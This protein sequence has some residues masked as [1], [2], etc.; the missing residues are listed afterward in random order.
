MNHP[1]QALSL[2]N[3]CMTSQPAKQKYMSMKYG[4]PV[5]NDFFFFV[6]LTWATFDP[7][8]AIFFQD[9]WLTS[10]N[11]CYKESGHSYWL[12]RRSL[13]PALA[14]Q[15]HNILFISL[16][17]SVKTGHHIF[18]HSASRKLG[19]YWQSYKVVTRLCLL[20]QRNELSVYGLHKDN[21]EK[22]KFPFYVRTST[23]KNIFANETKKGLYA[24]WLEHKWQG[25]T[26]FLS[27]HNSFYLHT[28]F[29]KRKKIT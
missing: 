19:M 28:L 9:H 25:V 12:P 16:H 22:L 5:I 17:I 10:M 26:P 24:N 3:T 21:H 4:G 27:Q 23:Q 8:T 2:W 6:E 11:N 14:W 13:S 29:R 15:R 1:D 7:Q 18:L 20:L